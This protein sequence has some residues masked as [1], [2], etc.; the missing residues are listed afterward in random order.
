MSQHQIAKH[1][2]NLAPHNFQKKSNR[3]NKTTSNQCAAQTAGT[4]ERGSVE[5]GHWTALRRRARG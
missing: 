2:D 4:G 1:N 3:E 5:V